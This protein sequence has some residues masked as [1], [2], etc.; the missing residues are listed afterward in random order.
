MT[1]AETR[2]KFEIPGDKTGLARL[3]DIRSKIEFIKSSR[4][5]DDSPERDLELIDL[6]GEELRIDP[7]TGALN[8]L[9]LE[10]EVNKTISNKDGQSGN[11]VILF[12]IDVN[13]FS[14]VNKKHGHLIGDQ[15]LK[16]LVQGLID[17]HRLDDLIGVSRIAGNEFIVA[18]K[19]GADVVL[20]NL[21]ETVKSRVDSL[22]N[23]DTRPD[24]SA[25]DV[26]IASVV[27]ESNLN[28]RL[29]YA[30]SKDLGGQKSFSTLYERAAVKAVGIKAFKAKA[31]ALVRILKIQI[32]DRGKEPNLSVT[33][34][35]AKDSRK[36]LL[37]IK[38]LESEIRNNNHDPDL[39]KR[40]IELYE[41]DLNKDSL[42][43][44][45]NKRFISE[46]LDS[47]LFSPVVER[48]NVYLAMLD[49]GGFKKLNQKFGT[50]VGDLYL[51]EFAI[52]IKEL[53]KSLEDKLGALSKVSPAR[54]GGDEFHILITGYDSESISDDILHEH[55]KNDILIPLK[56]RLSQWWSKTFPDLPKIE[57]EIHYGGAR[58]DHLDNAEEAYIATDVDKNRTTKKDRLRKRLSSLSD[59]ALGPVSPEIKIDKITS[60]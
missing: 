30:D 1:E 45:R 22:F 12:C 44:I 43:G 34:S 48:P 18:L 37:E 59:R 15:V 27:K 36:R 38:R 28:Y 35:L 39:L 8:S 40:L 6:L 47:L 23:D 32:I 33:S 4:H 7:L 3:A 16:Y 56:T 60:I 26:H 2:L 29:G 24:S 42:T 10:D 5:D 54:T 57:P 20:E 19:I 25:Q 14:A 11:R 21:I 9:G 13:G 17:K 50:D 58:V 52:I 55:I 49:I 46:E 53:S 51:Q 41:E 31:L